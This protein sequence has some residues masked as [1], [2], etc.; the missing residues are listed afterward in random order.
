M[1]K[2]INSYPGLMIIRNKFDRSLKDNYVP[3]SYILIQFI[4]HKKKYFNC[5]E[6]L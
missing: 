5:N 6:M 2:K 4:F 1:K 3:Q